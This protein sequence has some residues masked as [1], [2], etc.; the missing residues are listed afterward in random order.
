ML[1]LAG[2]GIGWVYVNHV[3]GHAYN[4]PRAAPK[5]AHHTL[6]KL[7]HADACVLDRL[8]YVDCFCGLNGKH[9]HPPVRRDVLEAMVF[10]WALRSIQYRNPDWKRS[11]VWNYLSRRWPFKLKRNP[12]FVMN[13]ARYMLNTSRDAGTL[14]GTNMEHAKLEAMCGKNGWSLCKDFLRALKQEDGRFLHVF[15]G[16]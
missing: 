6:E 1:P 2:L 5:C 10:R 11:K 4:M 7:E 9:K 16:D 12:K 8:Y 15:N 13:L 14:R 3:T